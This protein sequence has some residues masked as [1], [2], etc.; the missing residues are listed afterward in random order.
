MQYRFVTHTSHNVVK[1]NYSINL[2]K[3]RIKTEYGRIT[4]KTAKIGIGYG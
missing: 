3:I 2:V 1:N 4:L